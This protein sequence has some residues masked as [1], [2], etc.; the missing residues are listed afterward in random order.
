[1]NAC[2]TTTFYT[3]FLGTSCSLRSP[4]NLSLPTRYEYIH[5]EITSVFENLLP[6]YAVELEQYLEEE[7]QKLSPD[8]RLKS[9]QSLLP[10]GKKT[11]VAVFLNAG[12]LRA[13]VRWGDFL[14][15]VR[16][17]LQAKISQLA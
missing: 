6:Y 12:R 10:G 7:I 14:L 5:K 13:K 8:R 3:S 1:L 2:N 11:P 15:A 17:H 16:E 9:L 4:M